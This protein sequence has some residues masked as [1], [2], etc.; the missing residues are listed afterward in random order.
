MKPQTQAGKAFD[1]PDVNLPNI[2]EIKHELPSSSAS[3]PISDIFLLQFLAYTQYTGT[4]GVKSIALQI[5]MRY[6]CPCYGRLV[7]WSS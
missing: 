4:T 5:W 1:G 7:G 6:I 2:P 3:K